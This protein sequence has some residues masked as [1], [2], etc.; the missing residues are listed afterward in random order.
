MIIGWLPVG[1]GMRTATL[2][3]RT[4]AER[5]RAYLVQGPATRS[6]SPCCGRTLR[7]SAALWRW[8]QAR[9]GHRIWRGE[10]NSVW[11]RVGE[12]A[13]A[14]EQRCCERGLLVRFA[15]S[16]LRSGARGP[17]G[18]RPGREVQMVYCRRG[19]QSWGPAP[20]GR[21]GRLR[22]TAISKGAGQPSATIAYAGRRDGW[23]RRV[24]QTHS[25]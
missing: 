2:G 18:Y 19:R 22:G 20:Q 8:N 24:P 17:A 15:A 13:S 6:R 4:D 25:G 5:V 7:T 9:Q 14:G 23:R 16:R 11:S 3:T 10:P 12:H 21:P 1:G